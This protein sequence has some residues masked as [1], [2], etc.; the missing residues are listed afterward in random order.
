MADHQASEQMV[1][2][3]YQVRYALSML[4]KNDDEKAQISIEK[5]DDIAFS[6]DGIPKKL[7][8]LKHH[9]K[10]H[11]D[12]TDTSTDI[13]R[14]LKVWIDEIK[15]SP[16]LLESTKF[17]IV[18]T[19]SAPKQS[20]AYYLKD[21]DNRNADL[22]YSKLKKALESSKNMSHQKFYKAFLSMKE[23]TVKKLVSK[24]N[25]IDNSSN[26]VDVESEIKNEIK[27]SCLPQHQELAYE[28][29]EGWWFKK[30]IEALCSVNPIFVS[31]SQIRSFI[32]S[33]SKEYSTDN[34]PIDIFDFK[35]EIPQEILAKDRVFYEQLK[36]ISL[37]SK[38]VSLALTDYYKAYKQRARWV[39][40]G[41][42]YINELEEYEEKLVDEWQHSFYRMEEDLEE[43]GDEI[44]EKEKKK[45]GKELYNNIEEKDIRIRQRCSEAFIMRGSY[46]ML[47]N[48][49]KIGWHIDF[50]ERLK[51]ILDQE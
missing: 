50:Y 49:L 25:V 4:L 3:L 29:L 17:L 9:V 30:S 15:K 38:R 47:S 26:I 27:Y 39:R 8:Q 13:W 6:N 28:R 51:Y 7:I 34:L 46:H 14:T 24:I 43:Y 20:A 44:I 41:L 10:N 35:E 21:D 18:T 5:F 33:I 22:A 45:L 36:L 37:G 12:L 1:G 40:N 48:E 42:L 16:E 19:A 32:V 2:Y 11:G 31:Q 23:E